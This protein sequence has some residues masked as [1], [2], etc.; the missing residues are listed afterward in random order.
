MFEHLSIDEPFDSVEYSERSNQPVTSGVRYSAD[1]STN[2]GEV[3]VA[4]AMLFLDAH[5]LRGVAQHVWRMYLEGELD[6]MAASLTTNSAIDVMR[7]IQRDFDKLIPGRVDLNE[8]PCHACLYLPD[9]QPSIARCPHS[10]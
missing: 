9:Q 6:P 7:S 10:A 3:R 1:L 4:T 2:E 8:A 5:R